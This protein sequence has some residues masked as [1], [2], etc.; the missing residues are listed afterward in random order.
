RRA[1]PLGGGAL[2]G[3]TSALPIRHLIRRDRARGRCHPTGDPASQWGVRKTTGRKSS[4][5]KCA[6]RDVALHTEGDKSGP[7]RLS[8][9]GREHA[10][11]GDY[12]GASVA[13]FRR[14]GG[15]QNS[16]WRLE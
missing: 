9:V 14:D 8:A 7:G 4:S 10:R 5:R 15:V 11:T 12:R 2:F 1:S 16:G 3:V 6:L 13:G